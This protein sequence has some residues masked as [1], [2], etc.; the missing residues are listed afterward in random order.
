M[1]PA[2]TLLLLWGL[3]GSLVWCWT[4]LVSARRL[5]LVRRLVDV[6]PQVLERWPRVSVII[7][8]C[9]EAA[10]LEP[11]L[12]TLLAVDYPELEIIVVDDRSSDGTGA[13]LDRM[14]A[15]DARVRAVHVTELPDGWLGKVHALEVGSRAAT[16]D[17][18]LYTD[19]DVHFEPGALA[20]AVALCLTEALD[21]LVALPQVTSHS[22]IEEATVNAVG[23]R[24]LRI[25]RAAEIGNAGSDAYA[26]VGAFNLVR[27]AALERSEGFAW[28]RME[29]LDDVGLGLVLR[30][31]H[32]R[33]RFVLGDGAVGLCWY[34]SMA[35]MA[36]GFEKN[37]FGFL[38]HYQWRRVAALLAASWAYVLAPAAA[39]VTAVVWQPWMWIPAAA[40]IASLVITAVVS[41]HRTGRRILPLLLLP[42]GRL[43]VPLLVLRSAIACRRDGGIL[44]RGTRYPLPLLRELQRVRL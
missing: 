13:I 35:D 18:L 28:L 6:S 10:T 31:A 34:T 4:N 14:A 44:W 8:A 39:I 9:N 30:R 27:R 12:T 11:A 25:T 37:M 3:L 32:A 41:A 36:K 21:H 19:A 29:V 38:A 2:E 42:L 40:A 15:R 5:Y 23:E 22:I 20:K 24:Y 43:V 26:G 33:S 17:W 1:S 16:G 7:A